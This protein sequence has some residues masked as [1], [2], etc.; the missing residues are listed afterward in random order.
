MLTIFTTRIHAN[1]TGKIKKKVLVL[2]SRGQVGS[3]LCVYLKDKYEVYGVD[4]VNEKS[5]DLRI[6]NN[7]KIKKLIKKS[8]F[9]FFL[10]YDVGGSRYMKKHQNS[11][12][13][14]MNNT[15]IMQNTFELLRINNKKFIFA[16]SQMSNMLFSSYG[17]LKKIGENFTASLNNLSV[18]FWN[19]YGYEHDKEKSHVITDFVHKAIKYGKIEMLTNGNEERDFLY[20]EDCCRGLEK[21]MLNFNNLKKF[22]VIDLGYGRFSK[23]YTVAK[24][25]KKLLKNEK[26][27]K[28]VGR[29]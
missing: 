2:G 15:L 27:K 13:F 6:P 29:L 21:I 22:K 28:I 7:K 26:K 8:D 25:I 17:I 14:I 3:A 19:V 12:S 4:I 11:Y 24:T 5:Q 9:V 23:I 20:I 18:R 16:T 10:A 1:M